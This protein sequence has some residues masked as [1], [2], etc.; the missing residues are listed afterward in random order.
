MVTDKNTFNHCTVWQTQHFKLN[1]AFLQ[2]DAIRYA[3]IVS[4]NSI[5]VAH[6][7]WFSLS[8]SKFLLDI[9]EKHQYFCKGWLACSDLIDMLEGRTKISSILLDYAFLSVH[10]KRHRCSRTSDTSVDTSVNICSQK[11]L[12][13]CTYLRITMQIY[14][15]AVK[16]VPIRFE[17]THFIRIK[18]LRWLTG[19]LSQ[20]LRKGLPAFSTVKAEHYLSTRSITVN[21]AIP[22]SGNILLDPVSL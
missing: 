13:A 3:Y 1:V 19:P 4:I 22:D 5:T 16:E 18:M 15:T 10:V 21:I 17:Q 7:F 14:A 6:L 20:P 8:Y 9:T 12:L 11:W 2:K